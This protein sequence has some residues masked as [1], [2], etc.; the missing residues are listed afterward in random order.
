MQP[1]TTTEAEDR[2]AIILA[3]RGESQQEAIVA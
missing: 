3:Q 1:P 2:A